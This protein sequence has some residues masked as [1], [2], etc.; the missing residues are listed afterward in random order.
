MVALS[1]RQ[2]VVDLEGPGLPSD[3]FDPRLT[4]IP[5]AAL[6]L[7]QRERYLLHVEVVTVCLLLSI[8]IAGNPESSGAFVVVVVVVSGAP[9]KDAKTR[10]AQ[11]QEKRK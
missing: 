7:L 6:V 8:F 11:K 5:P 2:Q 10:P 9:S 4:A 1:V 3:G